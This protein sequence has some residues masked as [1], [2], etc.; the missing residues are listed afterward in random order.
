L[1]EIPILAGPGS[2]AAWLTGVNGN[3]LPSSSVGYRGSLLA[4]S[5]P[6]RSGPSECDPQYPHAPAV[7][8]HSDFASILVCPSCGGELREGET[9]EVRC[10]RCDGSALVRLGVL[11][12][13][14][15]RDT[16]VGALGARF[17]LHR[18]EE[19]A[20]SYAS[21]PDLADR[22]LNMVS[23]ER[24][25]LTSERL[26][27]RARGGRRRYVRWFAGIQPPIG[28]DPGLGI[29]DK[30]QAAVASDGFELGG[31]YALEAGC[32]P[33]YHAPGFCERFQSVIL[34]DCS[35]ANLVLAQRV[36]A[37]AGVDRVGLIR[38]DVERLPVR[39][40]SM[41]FIHENGVIEHVADPTRMLSEALRVRAPRGTFVCLSPNRYPI[42]LEPH[43]RL[44]LFGLV[45][46]RIRRVLIPRT[47]G[48]VSE[49]G[50]DLLSLS[51][52]RRSFRDAGA[53]PHIF[54]LPPGLETTVRDTPI[55][56]LAKAA[57][58][59]PVWRRLVLWAVNRLL[60]PIA[61]YHFAVVHG[62]PRGS[63]TRSDDA[64]A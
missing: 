36:C 58:D 30:V 21:D 26:P 59:H 22:S 50:T 37:R 25:G 48:H 41:D 52:L 28:P 56:R 7:L 24:A 34:L 11:D 12:F 55:R 38:A 4:H 1:V 20:A 46:E 19:L 14:H 16:L 13:L 2:A 44:P 9:R 61:P 42:T 29:L 10:L 5:A 45:P 18:D 49:E 63:E 53:E 31:R 60:L 35:L 64:M 33:G 62:P 15:D 57:L 6:E 54:F 40:G 27:A 47:S 8:A 23:E 43:F 51:A 3:R 17:D 32:G 39:D